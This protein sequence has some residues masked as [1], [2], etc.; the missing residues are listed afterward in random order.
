MQMIFNELSADFP[1]YTRQEGKDRMF[2]FLKT[3]KKMKN[4]IKNDSV[5]IDKDYNGIK[6]SQNY[7]IYQWR[8]DKSVDEEVKRLFRSFINKA[9]TIDEMDFK[10]NRLDL[11]ISELKYEDKNGIGCLIAYETD[12]LVISFLSQD[13]W[14]KE[15]IEGK[16]FSLRDN[17]EYNEPQKVCVQNVSNEE[18]IRIFETNNNHLNFQEHFEIVSG[19]D[20]WDKRETLFP[21]L[22][23]CENIKSQLTNDT[24]HFHIAQIFNKLFILDRYFEKYDGNFDKDAIP[25]TT[26]ESQLTLTQYKQEHKFRTPDG[27]ELIFS[28]HVRFTGNYDGRIFFYPDNS[29]NKCYIGHIGRKLPTV[30]YPS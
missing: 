6:L 24:Q 20:L 9:T 4:I 15:I 25:N 2:N 13:Y 1:T 5:I 30:K 23:F 7:T 18:N 17:F 21:N 12:N 27:K 3:Y 14:S 29:C 8:E 19:R 28:W 11:E 22:I 26:P 16:Y 10:E